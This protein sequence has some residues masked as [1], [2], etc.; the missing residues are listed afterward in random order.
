MVAAQ[1]YARRWMFGLWP[2][3][4]L[5]LAL[6]YPSRDRSHHAASG[7]GVNTISPKQK[8]PC[9]SRA[10]MERRAKPL[11]C[12]VMGEPTHHVLRMRAVLSLPL[13]LS[14]PGT[15]RRSSTHLVFAPEQDR[16]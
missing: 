13:E 6:R 9:A 4:C 10:V 14:D 2:I 3:P 7:G 16:R 11:E 12:L 1:T 15:H 5:L 8:S